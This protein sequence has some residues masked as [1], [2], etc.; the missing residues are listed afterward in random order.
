MSPTL[1]IC[2][3]IVIII[4]VLFLI[5]PKIKQLTTPQ[6]EVKDYGNPNAKIK[7]CFIGSMHGNE[8]AGHNCLRQLIDSG[9]FHGATK[10]KSIFVRIIPTPNP[11]GLK[12]GIRYQPNPNYP[13]LNRNFQN[14]G[15]EPI[16][17]KIIKLCNGFDVIVDF[18]EGWGFH[19]LQPT[20]LGSTISPNSS[21]VA[22]SIANVAASALNKKISDPNKQFQILLGNDCDIKGTLSC[23]IPNYILVEITGQNN[24]QPMNIRVDQVKTVVNEV[25]T[26][27]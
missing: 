27:F 2:I 21:K 23:A 7:I 19:R 4:L 22:M 24:V 10:D 14:G 16:S 17:Q 26:S 20:S 5:W 12:Y 15:L 9:W 18:H 11:W 1:A 25:I 8:P 6:I 3:L 13:D